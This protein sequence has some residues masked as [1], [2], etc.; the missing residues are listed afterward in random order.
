MRDTTFT[1]AEGSTVPTADRL[2][3]MSVWMDSVTVTSAARG[4][5]GPACCFSP[6]EHP[7]VS[8]MEARSAA[9][10]KET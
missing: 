3:G 10:P 6:E 7:A 1:E 2:T 5:A 4:A 9:M 8:R